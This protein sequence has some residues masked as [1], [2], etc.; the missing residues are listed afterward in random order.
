MN[1]SACGEIKI[2]DFGLSKIMDDDDGC[3]SSEGM[4]LTS[5]GAGTYWYFAVRHG[6]TAATRPLIFKSR[7]RVTSRYLPPECFVVGKEPPK[8]SNKVDVWSLGVIFYQSLYGRKVTGIFN[9]T[10]SHTHI[11]GKMT[12]HIPKYYATF[13]FLQRNVR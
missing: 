4:E 10:P 8:I 2:T 6:A 3:G 7:C 12:H 5:Q 11:W 9:S 1:G 13:F